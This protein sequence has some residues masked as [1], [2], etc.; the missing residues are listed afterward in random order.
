MIEFWGDFELVMR[1]S[2]STFVLWLACRPCP[3][4]LAS[5]IVNAYFQFA[6]PPRATSQPSWSPS[7]PATCLIISLIWAFFS[8][9]HRPSPVVSSM[10]KSAGSG[11]CD[12]AKR[13]PAIGASY[14]D[15]GPGCTSRST[16]PAS[17]RASIGLADQSRFLFPFFSF[18]RRSFV[19]FFLL[20]AS[21]QNV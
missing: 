19:F 18:S 7:L 11:V 14:V 13:M 17:T 2:N 10:L 16:S 8:S 4:M 1:S 6:P 9:L 15:S 21:Q 5:E 20:L 12:A 3:A